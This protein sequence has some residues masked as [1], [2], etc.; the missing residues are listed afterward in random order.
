MRNA[1]RDPHRALRGRDESPA[2]GTHV[3]HARHRIRELD[4]GMDVAIAERAIGH[5]L[6]VAEDRSRQDDEPGKFF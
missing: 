6:G 1:R 5:R 3:E 4:P 2:V